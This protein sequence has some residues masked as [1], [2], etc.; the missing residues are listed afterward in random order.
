MH[1]SPDPLC[2]SCGTVRNGFGKLSWFTHK[3]HCCCSPKV[4]SAYQHS[5]CI[6]A[7]PMILSV[8]GKA[9]LI[10]AI[11]WRRELSLWLAKAQVHRLLP[12]FW[13]M[14][15]FSS[16]S[17][18]KTCPIPN[19]LLQ[20]GIISFLIL[21][22]TLTSTYFWLARPGYRDL[23]HDIWLKSAVYKYPERTEGGHQN[24]LTQ[25]PPFH[26]GCIKLLNNM[27][28][29]PKMLSIFLAVAALLSK[30]VPCCQKSQ[31]KVTVP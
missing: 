30:Q 7:R 1:R 27:F 25:Y 9:I 4:S 5:F 21:L 8:I 12:C 28:C 20:H 23:S 3:T 29:C 14:H 17:F 11:R 19:L 13:R 2:Q 22:K 16:S 31:P 18:W 6:A 24:Q 10:R 26:L 15:L